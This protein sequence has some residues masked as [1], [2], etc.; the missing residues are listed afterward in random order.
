MRK[1]VLSVSN[2]YTEEVI[3]RVISEDASTCNIA[4]K[5]GESIILDAENEDYGI[6]Y[7]ILTRVL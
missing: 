7:R 1:F 2:E 3:T 4:I 5:V 6:K